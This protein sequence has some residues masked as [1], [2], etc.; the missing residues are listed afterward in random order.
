MCCLLR[1]NSSGATN[2][3]S[4]APNCFNIDRL[5]DTAS[6]FSG[7]KIFFTNPIENPVIIVPDYQP[8]YDITPFGSAGTSRR[9]DSG[10]VSD[11]NPAYHVDFQDSNS[12]I[13]VSIRF[14]GQNGTHAYG[15]QH[16]VIF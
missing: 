9:S 12:N 4:L 13:A 16:F 10:S 8:T 11:G 3:V 2:D 6:N 1:T 7:Y 14:S 5:E 15:V